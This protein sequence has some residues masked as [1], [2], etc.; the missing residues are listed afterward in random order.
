MTKKAISF[1]IEEMRDPG[2]FQYYTSKNTN[3]IGC[4]LD[5]TACASVAL[6]QSHPLVV[7]FGGAQWPRL[8]FTRSPARNSSRN[9][10]FSPLP[11]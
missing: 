4:D 7:Y 8:S 3:S 5:D 1:L 6:Q 9:S 11:W 10:P 2:L